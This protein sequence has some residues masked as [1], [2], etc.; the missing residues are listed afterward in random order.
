MGFVAFKSFLESSGTPSAGVPLLGQSAR[1]GLGDDEPSGFLQALMKGLDY[2]SRPGRA[3]S[4]AV[5]EISEGPGGE[6]LAGVWRG[7]TGEYEHET[8]G[9]QFIPETDEDAD[10]TEKLMK[11]AARFGIDAIGDPLTWAFTPIG[12]PLVGGLLKTVGKGV[13][14]VAGKIDKYDP[15]ILQELDRITLP[16]TTTLRRI[17]TRADKLAGHSRGGYSKRISDDIVTSRTGA[18]LPTALLQKKATEAFKSLGLHKK[19]TTPERLMA[20]D[21]IETGLA[22][23]IKHE[24]PRVQA[25]AEHLHFE[26]LKPMRGLIEVYKDATGQKFKTL[27]PLQDVQ[28]EVLGW[29]RDPEIAGRAF[30][31]NKMAPVRDDMW[32][33]FLAGDETFRRGGP[34]AEK[35][36]R[37]MKTRLDKIVWARYKEGGSIFRK[38]LK[39]KD[40]FIHPFKGQEFY[41]PQVLNEKGLRELSQQF[42][43]KG[44]SK[45]VASISEEN[46]ISLD[47]AKDIVERMA[48]P[49]RH[50]NVELARTIKIGEDFLEKDPM[51][52]LPR[53]TEKLFNRMSFGKRFG[54][55]GNQLRQLVDDAVLKEGMNPKLGEGI[56]DMVN[57]HPTKNYVLDGL[58]RKI[59]GFQV[60]TKMGPL[61][62][63][64][65]LSQ[66]INTGIRDG[67]VNFLKGILRS[68]SDEGARAGVVAYQRGIHDM[69]MRLT[70]GEGSWASRYLNMVGF[71]PAE[72]MN[73][74]LAA[75]SG[76][77]T[78]EGLI[79]DAGRLTDDLIRRG[80][81]DQDVFAAIANGK[82]LNR[83][84]KLLD[85]AADRVGLLASNAT[86]HATSWEDIPLAWQA[87]GMRMMLQY[88]SF[89]YQQSRFLIRE[90]MSPAKD[91]FIS[92]GKKGS[93]APLARFAVA[94]GIGAEGVNYLRTRAREAAGKLTGLDYEPREFDEDNPIWDFLQRSMYVGGLGVAGDLVE[95]ASK[96][97]L[98]GWLLGPTIGDLSDL[99]EG[100]I[101]VLKKPPEE[102]NWNK[103]WEETWRSI[104]GIGGVGTLVPYTKEPSTHW[105]KVQSLLGGK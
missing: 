96:R 50:G 48:N 46:K 3:V 1:G 82:K 77:V 53:Y 68:Q 99:T 98:K 51:V 79:D 12:R 41:A 49:A 97:D 38:N 64:S 83:G 44:V 5:G 84:P 16:L 65:N 17:T 86:Q 105:Q 30:M 100:T 36:Y 43:P 93:I 7:L 26:Q 55:D 69:L 67:G 40:F 70:G 42:R 104:P 74:L 35:F 72:R 63:L 19:A 75:N 37:K 15:R 27:Y 66:S 81:T 57:G 6:P 92:N 103:I 11:G 73:R 61:S 13:G 21:W 24:N 33:A 22:Q 94:T 58:A 47:E 2:F 71:T 60:M 9:E 39:D 10:L 8:L 90:V 88:K 102:I 85:D 76:I 45:L 14:K 78:A 89:V 56:I 54:L 18:A 28:K 95:R 62:T 20:R 91:W 52:W 23:G 101:G 59:M 32:K 80:V 31:S 34:G 4:E 25:L 87:P 29:A